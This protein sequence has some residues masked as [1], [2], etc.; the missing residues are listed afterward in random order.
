MT[1][2]KPCPFCGGKAKVS[3]W[4]AT[5]EVEIICQNEDCGVYQSG[6]VIIQDRENKED[7][8]ERAYE[9]AKKKWNRRVYNA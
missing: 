9:I 6:I 3:R 5:Y 8:Y 1:E 7:A 2:L 4:S